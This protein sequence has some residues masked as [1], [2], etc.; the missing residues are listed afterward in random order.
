MVGGDINFF[1]GGVGVTND[2]DSG[3]SSPSL[4]FARTGTGTLDTAANLAPGT[5]LGSGSGH[6]FASGYGGSVDHLGAT[7]TAGEPGYLG[8]VL[9]DGGTSLFGWMEVTFTANTPGGLVHQ[10]GYQT[11]G[12][13]ILVGSAVPEASESLVLM[14]GLSGLL[15]GTRRRK[16]ATA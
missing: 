14:A 2:A 15:L 11:S 16:R 5:I 1:F 9:D 10:W 6:L 4:E 3:A 8:F 13:P 12:G 7:F